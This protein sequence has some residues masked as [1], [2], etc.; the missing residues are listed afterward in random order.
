MLCCGN[1]SQNTEKETSTLSQYL[2]KYFFLK[3]NMFQ[4]KEQKDD[5]YFAKDV[6]SL[7]E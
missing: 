4:D 7:L 3:P 5:L 2:K 1:S 6:T